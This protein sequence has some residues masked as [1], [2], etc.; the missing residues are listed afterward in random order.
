MAQHFEQAKAQ[1][2]AM[3]GGGRSVKEDL[4]R[5]YYLRGLELPGEEKCTTPT[6]N[7]ERLCKHVH[8]RKGKMP[9]FSGSAFDLASTQPSP[10]EF[11]V[12]DLLRLS[13]LSVPIRSEVA[14][15]LKFGYFDEPLPDPQDPALD[16]LSLNQLLA[17]VNSEV[18]F[19]DLQSDQEIDRFLGRTGKWTQI[20]SD[21]DIPAIA[22][23]R[24]LRDTSKA[25]SWN[26]GDT[27]ISKLIAAKRP[28]LVPI[29]DKFIGQSFGRK[30]ANDHWAD[31]RDLFAPAAPGPGRNKLVEELEQITIDLELDI[32][33]LRCLDVILW[34]AGSNQRAMNADGHLY[35]IPEN[36]RPKL[37]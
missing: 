29:Y 5:A 6:D 23:W 37:S 21:D 16:G 33:S 36:C 11:S 13:L 28:K 27:R 32:S 3:S 1:L 35:L 19:E 10:D 17:G 25:R 34:M 15:D 30:N 4:V 31:L 22:L 12:E 9:L 20:E 18:R 8:F 24:A 26:M 2:D 14:R 7:D